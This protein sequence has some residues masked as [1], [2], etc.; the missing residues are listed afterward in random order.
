MNTVL[1]TTNTISTLDTYEANKKVIVELA[2]YDLK[3]NKISSISRQIKVKKN[4][5]KLFIKT[6]NGIKRIDKG[7]T[8]SSDEKKNDD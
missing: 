1:D 3:R 8:S 2:V 4:S 6:K 5:N 7:T